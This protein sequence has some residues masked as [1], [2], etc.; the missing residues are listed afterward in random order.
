M[1]QS[2][3][4]AYQ[5]GNAAQSETMSR[6]VLAMHPDH[7]GAMLLLAMSLDAQ[8]KKAEAMALFE[9]MTEL[10]PGT[11]AYWSNLGTIRRSLNKDDLAEHAFRRAL[12]LEPEDA[13]ALFNLGV[14]QFD[15]G[16]ISM[17]ERFC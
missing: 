5:A 2:A 6:Q 13:N 1:L 10:F 9:R 15:K 11:S 7:E 17:R 14:F 3:F 12:E 8:R 4:Q 16:A